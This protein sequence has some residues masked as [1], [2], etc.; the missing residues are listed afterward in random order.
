MSWVMWLAIILTSP[1]WFVLGLI[2]LG[3]IISII[4]VIIAGIV[5]IIDNLIKIFHFK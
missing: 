1:F 2:V 3:G 4:I 5:D